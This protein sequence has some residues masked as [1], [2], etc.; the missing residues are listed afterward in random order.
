MATLNDVI[1]QEKTYKCDE[2]KKTFKA[3]DIKLVEPNKNFS[4]TSFMGPSF[5]FLSK[6]NR[7]VGGCSYKPE[8]G[9]RNLACPHCGYV[10]LF[11]FDSVQ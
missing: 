9:D 7:I 6:D 10:H 4:A 5:M 11:G 2:C 8:D 1:K 3:E